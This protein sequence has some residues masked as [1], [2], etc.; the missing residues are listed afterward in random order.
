MSARFQYALQGD[1]DFRLR[2]W[3]L[4]K[5]RRDRSGLAR[6]DIAEA[7]R[8]KEIGEVAYMRQPLDGALTWMKENPAEFLNWIL[9]L[10]AGAGMWGW[11]ISK[12]I[13]L[14]SPHLRE[15]V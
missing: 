14:E 1:R 11:I 3:F 10:L 13:G 9:L 8:L 12:K 2:F 6:A 15:G 4:R 7:R 5:Q